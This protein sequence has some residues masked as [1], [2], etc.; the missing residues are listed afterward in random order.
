MTLLF[1]LILDWFFGDP[2]SL[3]RR[4]PHPVALIGQ[5][6]EFLDHSL[7]RKELT[8][9][10]L[11]QRGVIALAI[12]I[13]AALLVGA[14]LSFLFEKL[15]ILGWVVEIF[16]VSIFL[17]QKSLFD[18][19]GAVATALRQNSI[20][21]ARTE[22]G[23]IVGRNTDDLDRRGVCRAAIESLAE[24]FSDG[25]VA[26]ALW[27]A[28]LGLP[29]LL[30]YKAINTADSMIGHRND[31]YLHFGRAAARA[32]DLVNW[33]AARLSA[34]LIAAGYAVIGGLKKGGDTFSNT[35][36]EA[37]NHRSPNAGWP[38]AAMAFA[39]DI[40]LGGPRNYGAEVVNDRVINAAG[41]A[42]I[43]AGDIDRALKLFRNACFALW[44]V[45]FLLN[46]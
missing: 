24:N 29:G 2:Q 31:K 18:H 40:A 20:V 35:M 27:Y 41:R 17:A 34:L 15:A 9:A 46:G 8:E 1:S 10:E 4:V 38:E 30:A 32:D 6:I 13:I 25:V 16:V 11:R 14:L 23:K 5:G 28:I 37:G 26:P 33:P 22:V 43:D 44:I 36:R 7:N 12:L 39:L 19:V 42:D 45:A 3:W 21:E